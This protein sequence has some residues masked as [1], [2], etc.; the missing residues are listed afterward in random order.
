MQKY[1]PDY[2]NDLDKVYSKIWNLLISLK[3][4]RARWQSSV[5]LLDDNQ[6]VLTMARDR[7]KITTIDAIAKNQEILKNA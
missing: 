2:Y 5:T 6:Q 4:P 3:I 7:L 1:K